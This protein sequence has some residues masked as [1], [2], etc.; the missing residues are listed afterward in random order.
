MKKY[1][2]RGSG[3]LRSPAAKQADQSAFD[4]T[5]DEFV[6]YLKLRNRSP[7]TQAHY[8]GTVA[9][10]GRFLAGK[11]K[12]ALENPASINLYDL[13]GFVS[14][15]FGAMSNDSV[16]SHVSA[17]RTFFGWLKSSGRIRADPTELLESPKRKKNLPRFLPE[18]TAGDLMDAPGQGDREP[19][20]DRALL[21]LFYGSGL[22]LSELAAA[23]DS[24]LDVQS[25]DIRVMGK[26]QKERIVPLSEA[27]IQAWNA[28]Q[29]LRE[30][31]RKKLGPDMPLFLSNRGKALS[32]SM[33]GKI[34]RKYGAKGS[35]PVRMTPHM[36]RHSYA[37]HM[38]E[39]GA[40]LRAI[41]EML[42]HSSLAAT[43]RYTAVQ[44]ARMMRTYHEAHGR[45]RDKLR[46]RNSGSA[47]GEKPE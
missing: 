46:N 16:A 44:L 12:A 38:L 23:S 37:T 4:T 21:E 25:G 9:A 11:R 31:F 36:L 34:V 32:V 39:G 18:T 13:R 43:Q 29:P 14:T 17:L 24:A 8:A 45:A 2:P 5:L 10:F 3:P 40:D 47:D 35:N 27:F 33:I 20:R 41:Q 26:G 42:G 19:E 30:R 7:R 15:L 6:R 22:R 28:Y 1:T